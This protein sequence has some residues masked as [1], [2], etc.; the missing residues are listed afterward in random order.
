[1]TLFGCISVGRRARRRKGTAAVELA[2]CLPVLIILAM[3]SMEAT[4]L[5]FLR[6]RLKTAAYEGARTVTAPTQTSAAGITAATS[7]MTQRGIVSGTASCNPSTVDQNTAA[8]TQVT[9]TVSAPFASNCYMKPYVIG[10][11]VS[12]VTVSVTMIRQ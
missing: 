8:G 11:V 3:G 6:E 10:G 12:N 2:V 1:M 5:M 7:V 4:D 9:F